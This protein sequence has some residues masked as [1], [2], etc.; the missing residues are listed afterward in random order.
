MTLTHAKAIPGVHSRYPSLLCDPHSPSLLPK[1]FQVSRYRQ[2]AQR[3]ALLLQH[4]L[5]ASFAAWRHHTESRRAV[6]Q[7]AARQLRY[8]LLR[9]SLLSWREAA[10]G[11][12]FR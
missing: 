1:P 9:R 7:K 3:L 2:V 4:T 12:G 10:A 6:A 5:R 8:S 11:V